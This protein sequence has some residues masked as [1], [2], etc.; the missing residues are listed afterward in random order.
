[1]EIVTKGVHYEHVK[2]FEETSESTKREKK[3][4]QKIFQHRKKFFLNINWR[5]EFDASISLQ[6]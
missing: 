6:M 3:R 2:I 5:C 4:I 1:V